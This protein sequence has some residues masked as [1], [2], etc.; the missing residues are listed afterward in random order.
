MAVERSMRAPQVSVL[1]LIPFMFIM[2]WITGQVDDDT[3]LGG[4]VICQRV[5]LP[6]RRTSTV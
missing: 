6:S 5:K 4:T 2:I 1:D 3:K